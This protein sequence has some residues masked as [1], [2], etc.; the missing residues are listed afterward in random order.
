MKD[1]AHPRRAA[2]NPLRRRCDVVEAWAAAVFAAALVAGA[3]A[4]G[5][6]AGW[7][8]YE[9]GR[10]AAAEQAAARHPVEGRLLE[11]AGAPQVSADRGGTAVESWAQVR[12][13]EPGGKQTEGL[14]PV[15]EDATRGDRAV[16]WLDEQGRVTQPPDSGA[17]VWASTIV[18][19]TFAAGGAAA[20]AT[21]GR[22]WQHHAALRR[23]MA[24]WEADWAKTEPE[25]SRRGV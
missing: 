4:A 25:W 22:L 11:D 13:Q 12:W 15:P 2:P 5:A 18:V 20:L 8:T 24:E 1:T 21:G 7:M 23:R 10:S 17:D 14:I 3:P 16:V 6:A 19:G 9:H